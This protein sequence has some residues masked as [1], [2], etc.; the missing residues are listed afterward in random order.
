[1][2]HTDDERE[3]HMQRRI[4]A[5]LGVIAPEYFKTRLYMIRKT[6]LLSAVVAQPGRALD[7]L[8]GEAEDRAVVSSNLTDGIFY[9]CFVAFMTILAVFSIILP[10][11]ARWFLASNIATNSCF[12]K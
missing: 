6:S 12:D 2:G 7:L 11:A 3:V 8:R 5:N 1:M 10:D 9:I 4:T